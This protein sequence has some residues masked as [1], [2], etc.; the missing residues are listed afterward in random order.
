MIW[1]IAHFERRR[2]QAGLALWVVL[3][4]SQALVA[5]LAFA[6]LEAFTAIAPQLKASGS[7]IGA[8]DLVIKPTLNTLVLLLL[9]TRPLLAMG[10]FA[11]EARSG[12]LPFWL[13]TPAFSHQVVIGKCLGL[14][15]AGLPILLGGL[16]TL[17]LTGFGI[18]MD[19]PRLLLAA[20]TLLL[21]DFWVCAVAVWLS[22]LLDH[23]AAALAASLGLF[24]SLWLSDTL[25]PPGSMIHAAALSPRLTPAFDG[26][27]RAGDTLFFV[28]TIACALLLT[29]YR[30]ARRRGEL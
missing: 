3:A 9:L 17:A 10:T 27:W 22:A 29:M 1:S 24:V 28:T 7:T 4:V 30:F 16:I 25:G 12:R 26:L 13:A 14:W 18:D 20:G 21:F 15:L 23:P 6:Q 11:G 5:W 8:M 2:L 19:W